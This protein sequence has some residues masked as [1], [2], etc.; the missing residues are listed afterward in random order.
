MKTRT[1]ELLDKIDAAHDWDEGRVYGGSG[2]SMSSTATCRICG[3]KR[4]WDSGSRQNNINASTTFET[5]R[6]EEIPLREAAA[7]EC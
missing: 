4:H 2:D 1:K 3:L 7:L 6:G 5:A